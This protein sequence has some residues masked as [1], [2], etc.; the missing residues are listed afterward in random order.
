[1]SLY[2]DDLFPGDRYAD[3]SAARRERLAQLYLRVLTAL[4]QHFLESNR[5]HRCLDYCD[6]I[7]AREEWNED[8]VLAAMKARLNLKDRP[9]ALALYDHLKETLREELGLTPRADLK[10][11]AESLRRA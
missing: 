11:L 8:A 4:A 3:W 6:Q 10:A 5:P 7:L 2:T 1:M 9:G